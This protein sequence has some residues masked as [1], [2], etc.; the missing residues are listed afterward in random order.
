MGAGREWYK[1]D[2]K[3]T[4]KSFREN[5]KGSTCG[6]HT[7]KILKI[8]FE[9][10]V[11]FPTTLNLLRVNLFCDKWGQRKG[12]TFFGIYYCHARHFLVARQQDVF[13]DEMHDF[14]HV[15]V[16]A[17]GVA[18][19]AVG[20]HRQL[21][22]PFSEMNEANYSHFIY[23]DPFFVQQATMSSMPNERFG[24]AKW[25]IPCRYLWRPRCEP[26]F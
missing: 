2:I 1:T 17:D 23:T 18:N 15:A 19:L 4:E 12:N 13:R 14:L 21:L 5:L 26:G 6:K 22:I 8:Y 20:Y 10:E 16:S 7:E 11:K 24:L 9:G 25:F 3:M